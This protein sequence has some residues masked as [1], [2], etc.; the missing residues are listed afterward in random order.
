MNRGAEKQLEAIFRELPKP[1]NLGA[2][3][4]I[5]LFA[6]KTRIRNYYSHEQSRLDE[7]GASYMPFLQP[8][9]LDN[10]LSMK[11]KHRKNGKLFKLIIKEN[12][13]KLAGYHLVKGETLQPFGR[14]TFHARIKG[15]VNR[16]AAGNSST[17]EKTLTLFKKLLPLISDLVFSKIVSECGFYDQKK[18]RLSVE[19]LHKGKNELSSIRELD[20]WL[21][22]EL[23]RQEIGSN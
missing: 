10:L 1:A 12:E 23:F 18:I 13:N 19:N 20:W 9:I 11:V 14:S 22:F 3:N 4:W 6:L 21:S 8:S 2:E 16:I 5:D 17:D 7:I 15:I